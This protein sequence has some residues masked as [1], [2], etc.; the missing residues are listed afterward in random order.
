MTVSVLV[1]VLSAV[2]MYLVPINPSCSDDFKQWCRGIA[3]GGS[4]SGDLDFLNYGKHHLIELFLLLPPPPKLELYLLPTSFPVPNSALCICDFNAVGTCKWGNTV[5][6]LFCLSTCSPMLWTMNTSY[7]PHFV[8][9]I[10]SSMGILI[11]TFGICTAVFI[12]MLFVFCL[13]AKK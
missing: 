1:L 8:C 3:S 10:H 6:V 11:V 5:F 2:L 13:Y 4:D 12:G 7:K 9:L